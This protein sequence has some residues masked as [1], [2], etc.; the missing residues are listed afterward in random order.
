MNGFMDAGRF[1]SELAGWTARGSLCALPSAFLAVIGGFNQS[2][3][4]IA[5][6]TG[7]A[8]YVV[9]YAGFCASHAMQLTEARERFVRTLKM[10]AWLKASLLL[11][12]VLAWIVA[13]IPGLKHGAWA[14][15][16]GIA[17][18]MWVGGW[19][20]SMVSRLAGVGEILQLGDMNSLRWTLLTTLLQG[21][22]ISGL[23]VALTAVILGCRRFWVTISGS[24]ITPARSAG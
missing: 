1:R 14:F 21:A 5:M 13:L 3:E 2:S 22:F 17:P 4:I 15:G 12:V 24:R 19:S 6:A 7:F 20:I 18:D 10:S 9:L 8:A 11:G 23:L 16:V